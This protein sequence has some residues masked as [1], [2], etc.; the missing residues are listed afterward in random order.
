MLVG[1][2]LLAEMGVRLR[3][4]DVDEG[5]EGV[6]GVEVGAV[7]IPHVLGVQREI[8]G[9]RA[10]SIRRGRLWRVRSG[11]PLMLNSWD[12]RSADIVNGHAHN[13]LGV[14]STLKKFVY[15]T[16]QIAMRT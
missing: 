14:G 7:G 13:R 12:N 8:G 2:R 16:A 4:S 9:G 15:E 1:Q 3:A 6:L 11:L 5:E 10:E